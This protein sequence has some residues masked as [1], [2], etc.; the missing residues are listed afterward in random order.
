[1]GLQSKEWAIGMGCIAATLGI[2]LAACSG[3]DAGVT[4]VDAGSDGS[5][6]TVADSAASGDGATS[7]GA[8]TTGACPGSGDPSACDDGTGSLGT[9]TACPIGEADPTAT[10]SYHLTVTGSKFAATGACI[11]VTNSS[12]SSAKGDLLQFA[13]GDGTGVQNEL[14]KAVTQDPYCV[15]TL[16]VKWDKAWEDDGMTTGGP[17]GMGGDMLAASQKAHALIAW[18]HDFQRSSTSTPF[19]GR[20][21]SGG[22]S[23]LL[24]EVFHGSGDALFDHLQLQHTTPFA[25]IDKGCDSASPQEGTNKVCSTL[26]TTTEPQYNDAAGF[27]RNIT[28]DPNCDTDGGTLSDPERAALRAMSVV[29]TDVTKTT[30]HKTSV[31]AFMCAMAPN[32]TQG[33][34]VDVF[35][36]NADLAS[37]GSA[38][39]AGILDVQVATAFNGCAAGAECAP[40]VDCAADCSTETFGTTKEDR[41]ALLADIQSN[42]VLR[43]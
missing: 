35:G 37:A 41:A 17:A 26:P 15:R 28:H 6:D 36:V 7:D 32:A 2:T 1:M 31:S 13:G 38:A 16:D 21:S 9:K 23:E 8:A 18:V 10:I 24:F 20:G 27:V 40:H 39:Y 11:Y 29:T 33:Q 3:S 4:S 25:R 43:H 30:L 19:C 14:D 34:A 5:T 22:S 12:C 42:C